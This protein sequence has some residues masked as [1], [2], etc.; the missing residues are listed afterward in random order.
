MMGKTL[1]VNVAYLISALE[2]GRPQIKL[3]APVLRVAGGNHVITGY[4]IDQEGRRNDICATLT[5]QNLI[6]FSLHVVIDSQLNQL[7]I[8][9]QRRV[10]NGIHLRRFVVA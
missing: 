6:E 4:E 1:N 3:T 5:E 9:I 10:T 8:Q 7:K 2:R